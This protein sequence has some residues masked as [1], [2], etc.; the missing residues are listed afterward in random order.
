M[1]ALEVMFLIPEI[2]GRPGGLMRFL[3]VFGKAMKVG[4]LVNGTLKISQISS[5]ITDFWL[6][7]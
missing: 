4:K 2:M 5:V 3:C 6:C 7:R 1:L